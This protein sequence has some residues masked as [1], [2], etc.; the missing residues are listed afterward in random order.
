MESECKLLDLLVVLSFPCR[1]SAVRELV[2]N[3]VLDHAFNVI[4][5]QCQ[6]IFF[7]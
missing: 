7:K 1:S 5:E 2:A 4:S 3:D 6:L